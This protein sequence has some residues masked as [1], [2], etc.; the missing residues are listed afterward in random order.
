MIRT[1]AKRSHKKEAE[2]GGPIHVKET[3][4][5]LFLVVKDIVNGKQLMAN[6]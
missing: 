2:L 4:W 6:A 1:N 3:K 5:V